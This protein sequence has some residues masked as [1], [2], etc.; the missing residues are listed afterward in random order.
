MKNFDEKYKIIESF[1]DIYLPLKTMTKE[2]L[3]KDLL[4]YKNF[5]YAKL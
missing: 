4:I 5:K 2:D 3:N 1:L